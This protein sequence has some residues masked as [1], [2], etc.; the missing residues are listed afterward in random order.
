MHLAIDPD[1]DV[2]AARI[3]TTEIFDSESMIAVLPA[4]FPGQRRLILHKANYRIFIRS[5]DQATTTIRERKLTQYD[6]IQS[7]ISQLLFSQ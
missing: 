1:T 5:T 3:T 7:I 4:I 2:H 6:V